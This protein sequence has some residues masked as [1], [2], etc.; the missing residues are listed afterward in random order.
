MIEVK[1]MRLKALYCILFFLLLLS[2]TN[3]TEDNDYFYRISEEFSL[4]KGNS[5]KVKEIYL[6]ELNRYKESNEKKYLVSSKYATV[7]LLKEKRLEQILAIYDLLKANDAEYNYITTVSNYYL[8]QKFEKSLP[9]SSLT[10]INNAIAAD[11]ESQKKFHLPHL[12][13]FKG[14]VLYN[15]KSYKDAIIYFE[16]ALKIHQKREEPLFVASMH[17][18]LG[19]CYE[20][21]G[22]LQDAIQQTIV[23]VEIIEKIPDPNEEEL[24]FLYYIKGGLAEYYHKT[25]NHGLALELFTEEWN[26]G[27]SRKNSELSLISAKGLLSKKNGKILSEQRRKNIIDSLQYIQPLLKKSKEKLMYDEINYEYYSDFPNS[28][29]YQSVSN[30]LVNSIRI[31]A[32]NEAIELEKNFEA[33]DKSIIENFDQDF[34]LEKKKNTLLIF[35]IISLAIILVISVSLMIIHKKIKIDL[36]KKDILLAEKEKISLEE[37]LKFQDEKLKNFHLMLNIKT[38]TEKSFVETLKQIRKSKDIDVDKALKD[39]HLRM[40]NVVSLDHKNLEA[41]NDSSEENSCFRQLLSSKFPELTKNDLWFCIYFRL[42]LSSKEIALL[43]NVNEASV[44][45][46]KS[47]AKAKMKLD[48]ELNL[49]D[50]LRSLSN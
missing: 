20:K 8:A 41:I 47:K 38:E 23:A 39:L 2:C 10:Y 12:Y 44:R 5:Q 48:K 33:S 37:K 9:K 29:A 46:Y 24:T 25:G 1:T 14:R 18:N 19:M 30:A 43:E 49:T 32:K 34:I 13:H 36:I 35:A 11:E 17:N 28:V 4:Q 27:L 16:K 40:N 42:G 3:T 22:K 50:Y 45:V 26:Y 7:I 31:N 6:R 21:Q 15:L